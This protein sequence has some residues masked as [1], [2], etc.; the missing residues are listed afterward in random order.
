MFV[1]ITKIIKKEAASFLPIYQQ[2]TNYV[3]QHPQQQLNIHPQQ[4]HAMVQSH[5]AN[6]PPQQQQIYTPNNVP[7]NSINMSQF[8]NEHNQ[9]AQTNFQQQQ[10]F[11]PLA[12]NKLLNNNTLNSKVAKQ[13]FPIAP[14]TTFVSGGSN[15]AISKPTP[16]VNR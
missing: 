9:Q 5:P 13:E 3:H 6:L 15:I 8:N 7:I 10:F 4:Q 12:T 16:Q 11:N 1:I 14:G 2:Q